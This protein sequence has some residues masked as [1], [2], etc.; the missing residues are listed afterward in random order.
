LQQ[1]TTEHIQLYTKE[2]PQGPPIHVVV[3]PFNVPDDVPSEDEITEAVCHLKRGKA[4]GPSKMQADHVKAWLADAYREEDP[5]PTNWGLLVDLIQHSYQTG[6]FPAKMV[7]ALVVLLPKD[8]GGVCSIGLIEVIWK[9]ISSV[10]NWRL[11]NSVTFHDSLH[12]CLPCR[13]TDTAIIE[14]KLVQQLVVIIHQRRGY[15]GE[16]ANADKIDLLVLLLNFRIVRRKV[17]LLEID[18]LGRSDGVDKHPTS[19]TLP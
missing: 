2:E 3:A 7:W 1:T 5:N 14:A 18:A 11:L 10:E 12:G 6:E 4:P 15:L 19:D 13:G 16:W 17:K 9:V 8:S